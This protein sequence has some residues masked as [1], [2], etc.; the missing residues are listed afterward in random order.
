VLGS[1]IG[2]VAPNKPRLSPSIPAVLGAA[3][4]AYA[5]S[6]VVAC[7]ERPMRVL[8]SA[9]VGIGLLLVLFRL[10][11]QPH[12][13]KRRRLDRNY[14]I[15]GTPKSAGQVRICQQG[16]MELDALRSGTIRKGGI[17]I[18]PTLQAK[19]QISWAV[20]GQL[21]RITHALNAA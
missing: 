5:F 15:A 18:Q 12:S 21:Y 6:Y 8:F 19:V 7:N 4:A 16:T 20:Q 14:V 11:S 10:A 2:V 1:G 17:P 13:K 9:A 3:I